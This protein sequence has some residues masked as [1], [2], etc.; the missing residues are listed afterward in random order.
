VASAAETFAAGQR[1]VDNV[2][3]EIYW[4]LATLS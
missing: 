4:N 2:E 3:G 1:A